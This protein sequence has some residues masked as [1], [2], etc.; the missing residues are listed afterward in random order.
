[1]NQRWL[2]YLP[3]RIVD[4]TFKGMFKKASKWILY[5]FSSGEPAGRHILIYPVTLH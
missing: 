5:P 3:F 4:G 1:M 2:Q